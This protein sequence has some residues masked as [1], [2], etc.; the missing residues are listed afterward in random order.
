MINDL[1]GL[2]PI[3]WA[4]MV[5]GAA[6]LTAGM[7][8]TGYPVP[9][10]QQSAWDRY[11]RLGLTVFTA[12]AV[13]G[14][15]R[16]VGSAHFRDV[17][18][19]EGVAFF[20]LLFAC[21]NGLALASALYL[22]YSGL[23]LLFRPPVSGPVRSLGGPSLTRQHFKWLAAGGTVVGVIAFLLSITLLALD[24]EGSP[25]AAYSAAIFVVFGFGVA[26]PCYW[27]YRERD[28][29]AAQ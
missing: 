6:I 14:F 23:G 17:V 16:A 1:I 20:R 29:E 22:M 11:H 4:L 21:V 3:I 26:L 10:E 28:G 8:N 7:R 19:A 24:G 12:A 2:T 25:F 5:V 9:W 15:E 18:G 27:E 13:Q